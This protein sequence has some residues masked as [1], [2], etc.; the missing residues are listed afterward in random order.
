MYYVCAAMLMTISTCSVR[1]AMEVRDT[2][3]LRETFGEQASLCGALYNT[4]MKFVQSLY[5]RE[6]SPP[7]TIGNLIE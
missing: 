5:Q 4:I 2:H 3:R 7:G 6:M 1:S